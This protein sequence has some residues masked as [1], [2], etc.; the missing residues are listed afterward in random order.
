MRTREGLVERSNESI[1]A[2]RLLATHKRQWKSGDRIVINDEKDET[3]RRAQGEI[4]SFLGK[5]P[6]F[7]GRRGSRG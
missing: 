6:L 7:Y 4:W 3:R 2:E 1:D 5:T